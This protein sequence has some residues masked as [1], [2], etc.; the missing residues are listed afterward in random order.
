M[1]ANDLV[2]ADIPC[3]DLDRAVKFYSAVLGK[4]VNI[5]PGMEDVALVGA[6]PTPEQMEQAGSSGEMT[7]SVD[8]MRGGQ[9]GMNGPT[10]YFS[11]YGDIH[12][13]MQRVRDAGGEVLQEPQFQGPM[14]GTLAY[15]KDTEGNR[16][17]IQE[18]PTPEQMQ[19][20]ASGMNMGE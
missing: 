19:S 13:M 18:P 15:F 6:P 9:P 16:I 2:W 10:I 3:V 8:L 11:S 7:V 20:M 4:P 12:G 1:A 17:G 5:V 14:I